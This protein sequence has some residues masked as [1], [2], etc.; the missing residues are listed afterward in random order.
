MQNHNKDFIMIKKVNGANYILGKKVDFKEVHAGRALTKV[1]VEKNLTKFTMLDDNRDIN[2]SHVKDLVSS[3]KK[4]GQLMPIVVNQQLEVIEGQH[5]LRACQELQIPVSYIISTNSSS[6]DIAAINNMQKG[7]KNNDY[8]KHFSHDNHYNHS[9][10]RKTAKFMKAFALPFR[11]CVMLLTGSTFS[12]NANTRGPMP[13]FRS[14]TF[15]IKDLED[16]E[17][18]GKQLIKLKADLPNF[19]KINK[20]CMA[21]VRIQKLDNFNINV[22]YSQIPKNSKKFEKCGNIEDWIEAM[23][24]AYNYKLVTKGR[25]ANKR[26]SWKKD[27]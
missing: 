26:I 19:V 23:I 14:G 13:S 11:V 21:F 8:L 16:A 24:Q 4:L 15:K 1:M 22:A 2:D 3:I 20:F 27:I 12:E 17:R 7:W 9:E 10:Y 6:K 25:K 18:L 5:R